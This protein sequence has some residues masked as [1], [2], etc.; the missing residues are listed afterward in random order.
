MKDTISELI[1]TMRRL[2]EA[3]TAST[4]AFVAFGR[5]VDALI[6]ASEEALTVEQRLR[7]YALRDGGVAPFDALQA[8]IAEHET[9]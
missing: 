1:D 2:Q 8:V 7:Y 4:D 9:P 5:A 3:A 6:R